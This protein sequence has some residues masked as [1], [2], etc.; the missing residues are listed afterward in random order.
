M[1]K[2]RRLL[3]E[4]YIKHIK[5]IKF[6]EPPFLP[7]YARHNF[8]SFIVRITNL[9]VSRDRIMSYMLEK[10]IATRRGIMALHEEPYYRRRFSGVK[11]PVTEHVS[12]ATMILPL[13]PQM[14]FAEQDRVIENL[15]KAVN[16]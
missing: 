6:I 2:K 12:K 1:L 4:R 9:A 15:K 13:Y 3:A 14:T 11:L 7:E 8:Q 16:I 5:G 10:G